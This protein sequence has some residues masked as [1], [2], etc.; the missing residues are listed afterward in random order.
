MNQKRSDS[1]LQPPSLP[2]IHEHTHGNCHH[3]PQHDEVAVFVVE[4]WNI[5]KIGPVNSCNKGQR[6]ENDRENGEEF[7]DVV[8]TTGDDRMVYVELVT[9]NF[10]IAL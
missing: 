2:E 3:D 8:Q 9:Q 4:F 6:N 7:H 10:T 5:V 1:K